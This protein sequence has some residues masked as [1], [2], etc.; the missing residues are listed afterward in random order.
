MSNI[1]N[2][3]EAIATFTALQEANPWHRR[4]GKFG[5][6]KDGSWSLSRSN[7]GPKHKQDKRGE[8]GDPVTPGCGR[9]ARKMGGDHTCWNDTENNPPG[10]MDFAVLKGKKK[11]KKQ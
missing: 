4:D 11:K 3:L 6:G 9:F 5:F 2:F 7:K 10:K 8:K 1:E